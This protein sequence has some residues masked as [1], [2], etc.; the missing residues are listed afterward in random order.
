MMICRSLIPLS[1]S[2][3]ISLI[4]KHHILHHLLGSYSGRVIN[5]LLDQEMHL[6][7]QCNDHEVCATVTICL[8]PV[9]DFQQALNDWVDASLA[10]LENNQGLA[11]GLDNL[12]QARSAVQTMNYAVQTCGQYVIPLEALRLMIKL[13]DNVADIGVS[14]FFG[15][16][17]SSDCTQAHPLLKVGWTLL[18]SVYRTVQ[19]QKVDDSDVEGLAEIFDC[20]AAEIKGT[21]DVIQGIERLMVEVASLINEY[22]KGS[23]LVRPSQAQFTGVKGRITKCQA[24]LKDL[25]EKLRTRI[26]VYAAHHSKETLEHVEEMHGRVE[27]TQEDVKRRDTQKSSNKMR[28]WL[29]AHNSSINHKSARDTCVEGT[30]SWFSKDERFQKWL[31]E[32]GTP[33]LVSGGREYSPDWVVRTILSLFMKRD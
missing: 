28:K 29:K 10:L 30:G 23:S 26:M 1:S 14:S 5:F 18:S 21:P 31:H 17:D 19:Q 12:E 15:F 24:A 7:L 22:T 8:S 3:K 2:V 4:G 11:E 16:K 6:T 32:P 20:S 13:I 27:E 33:L 25:Y 9:V